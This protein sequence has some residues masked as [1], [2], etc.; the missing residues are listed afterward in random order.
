MTTITQQ[1]DSARATAKG[2]IGPWVANLITHSTNT[3][4]ADDLE[5]VRRHRPPI[6]ITALGS[7]K[8]ALQVVHDYGGLVFADV[9]NFNLARKAAAAG[10]DGLACISAG[11]GGHTGHLSAFAFISAVREFFDGWIVVGGGIAD[12]A[13]IAGAIAAGADF[14]YMG[15]R[16]LPSLESRAVQQYKQMVVDCGPDDVIVSAA[17]TGTAASWLAP[18]LQACGMDPRALDAAAA[19]NYDTRGGDAYKRWRDL[20]ACGQGLQVIRAIEPVAAIVQRLEEEY[21]RASARFRA[22]AGD[23]DMTTRVYLLGGYQT[24]FADN[25]AR[26]GMEIADM[27]RHTVH[28]A[29]WP[30]RSSSRRTSKWRT[31]ATSPRSCSAIRV[32]S[33]G[34]SL[35]AIRRSPVC[36]RRVTK[37]RA[38][39]EVSRYSRLRRISK[40]V[41]TGSRRCSA[42]SR[43]ATCRASRLR[44][45]SAGRRC[46]PATSIRK[47][48][49][50]WPRVFSDVADEYD[51]RFGLKSGAS[52]AHR[53]DQLRQRPA[54]SQR[55]DAPLGIQRAQLHA[56]RDR[57]P[58]DRRP[59]PQAGLRPDHRR[60]GDRVP[61][62]RSARPRAR[63]AARHR[64]RSASLHQG[65][66]TSH[67]ADHLR[68]ESDA[69]AR[70]SPTCSRTCA[71][72][73]PMRSERAGIAGVEQLDGIETHDCFTST[74]Y[75]AID[76]FGITA[77][78]Q[79][80]RA[81]EE[82]EIEIGGRIP[83]N[84]ER[85]THRR[86]P[87]GRRDR[88]AHGAR[89]L[90][91]DDGNGRRVSGRRRE[92]V[93][94]AQHRRQR[95][96][97]GQP[98]YRASR[99][100]QV[101]KRQRRLDILALR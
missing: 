81:I 92:D 36:P 57:Q 45:S 27:M 86:G 64:P 38:P 20:W 72:Q 95:D 80:W 11:A 96:D 40:R 44:N 3:R 21:V 50:P 84:P 79:S 14:V 4:F 65:L 60:R 23:S 62:E 87:S 82:G 35:R 26:N 54:Q 8:P 43:C 98:D 30:R 12:G 32:I 13:G 53:G 33:A 2:P 88:R 94:D 101:A 48:A 97:D 91:A 63:Q 70:A 19:R 16:F 99:L 56:G 76:H 74:E 10:V 61:R 58:D 93:R 47:R 59:H 22:L 24:D 49:I 67:G 89:L 9:V 28:A 85:R 15:T 37:A 18:S 46:G 39:R 73:S 17:I 1:L 100:S 5:L 31:S 34:C 78:G 83:V 90:Q 55:A 52:G 42:S 68:G 41:G 77:P 7:P 75:M 69:R 6:V 25:W 71:A 66:G 51:R 29:A